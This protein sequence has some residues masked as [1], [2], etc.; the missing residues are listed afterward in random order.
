MKIIEKGFI[1]NTDVRIQ[2]E[3]WSEDYNCF[4]YIV[5]AY[6]KANKNSNTLF[7]PEYNRKFRCQLN[8][9]SNVE[10][11]EVFDKLKSEEKE[12]RDYIDS[13]RDE[14]YKCLCN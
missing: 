9:N 3:D 8:F 11:K 12:L 10:A 14:Y 13:I 4:Q 6:P 5:A 1:S 7:G 2:I